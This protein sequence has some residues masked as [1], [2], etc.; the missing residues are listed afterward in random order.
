MV[1]VQ[2]WG[3]WLTAGQNPAMVRLFGGA[4]GRNGFPAVGVVRLGLER[5]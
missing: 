1:V 4:V 3:M 2:R 5:G